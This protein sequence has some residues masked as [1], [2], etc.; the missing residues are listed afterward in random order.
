LEKDVEGV[1]A[2]AAEEANPGRGGSSARVT[3][4]ATPL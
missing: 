2:V 1:E 3:H 4:D